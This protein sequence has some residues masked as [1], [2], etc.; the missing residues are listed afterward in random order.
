MKESDITLLL[1]HSES[2]EDG[3]V[4]CWDQIC[5]HFATVIGVGP[6]EKKHDWF[7]EKDGQFIPFTTEQG[8]VF[9]LNKAMANVRTP[10]TFLL[11]SSERFSPDQLPGRPEPQT[12]YRALIKE[13]DSSELRNNMQL[14]LCP[15]PQKS[16]RLFDGFAIPDLHRSFRQ[17]GWQVAE[18]ELVITRHGLPFSAHAIKQEAAAEKPAPMQDFWG[19][20]LDSDSQKYHRAET[21]FRQFLKQEATFEWYRLAAL[22]GLANT[23]VEQHKLQQANR[24]AR[25]SLEI[26]RR[27]RTPYLTL[28][29]I[30]ELTND[31][32]QAYRYL[33]AYLEVSQMSSQANM[34][35]VLSP[36]DCHFLMADTSFNEGQYEQ[37]FR[38][39]EQF[40]DLRE[41][42]VSPSVLERLLIYAIELG[43]YDK[44][45]RYF[46][47][48]FGDTPPEQLT[49]TQSVRMREVLSLF[50][51]QG[52]FDFASQ[53]YEKLVAHNPGNQALVHGWISI[54]IKNNEI[55][56]ARSLI[57]KKAS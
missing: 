46:H 45:V 4:A 44:A 20:I 8:K 51:D 38:H 48:M 14:R 24:I 22:N 56:K 41:G 43:S 42:Q 52:W 2:T 26:S 32:E 15:V 17:Q 39:Y 13:E 31:S 49:E 18:N 16:D 25:Q 34:D 21:G 19:A 10:F 28:F 55:E 33:E 54:L 12:C 9:G 7:P 50:T 37:A 11:E 27:Q 1:V 47:A 5:R 3:H 30:C 35:V 57:S 40:Y 23:L 6:K 36:A 29:K 53:T